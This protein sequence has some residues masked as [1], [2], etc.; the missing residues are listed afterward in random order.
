[1]KCDAFHDGDFSDAINEA[2]TLC[3]Y[4]TPI[5]YV[6]VYCRFCYNDGGFGGCEVQL[7][8]QLLK[9]VR[10]TARRGRQVV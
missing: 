4:T 6:A 8:K 1:M 5:R 3:T 7:R 9:T 2:G 10:I